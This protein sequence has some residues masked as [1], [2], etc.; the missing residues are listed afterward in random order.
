MHGR[1]KSQ[2]RAVRD[3]RRIS[4]SGWLPPAALV[5]LVLLV[6][7]P[8]LANGFVWDDDSYVTQNDTLRSAHGLWRIWFEPLSIPQYYPL[9]HTTFWLEHH[10]WGDA[11]AGYHAANIAL[12]SASVLLLWI[13][14]ARLRVPGAWLAAALFAVHPVEVETVAWI[15]ERKNLLSLALALGSLQAYFCFASLASTETGT[16]AT[17]AGHQWR[18]YTLSLARLLVALL[19]KTVVATLP[20]VVLVIYWWK[21][22]RITAHDVSPLLPFLALG[23]GLGL[24]TVWIE[25][26][27][28]GA[29]GQEWIFTPV[30]R[31]LIAGR[32]LW[33]YGAKL[34]WPEPLIF[35]Y[36]RWPI[37]PHAGWQYLFP[38][39]ALAAG[40]GLW[41]ARRRVGRGPLAAVLI[42][43][44]VLVP[45]LGFFDVYPF[46]YSF[47]ADHF[48]YHASVALLTLAAAG[49]V[50]LVGRSPRAQW[51]ISL[52]AILPLA[53]VARDRT[54][55][56]A[57][58]VTLHENTLALN[59][60]AWN[61]AVSLGDRLNSEGQYA[62][63]GAQYQRAAKIVQ[64]LLRGQPSA[65]PLTANLAACYVSV[66]LAFYRD[67]KWD[68]AN[69]YFEKAL[70][71]RQELIRDYPDAA[72]YQDALAWSHADIALTNLE[73]GRPAA[74]IEPYRKAIAIR[75]RRA[76]ERVPKNADRHQLAFNY[77]G[78][79]AALRDTGQ[80][81]DGERWLRKATD[82]REQLVSDEP[83]NSNFQEALG[84]CYGELGATE[85]I[86]GELAAAEASLR[87]A[88]RVRR[89]LALERHDHAIYR[90]Q[91][92][93]SYEG[94]GNLS[95]AMHR[96]Q[97]ADEAYAEA[98][99]ID[100]LQPAAH[101]AAPR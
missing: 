69:A 27:H 7:W 60:T 101:P 26:K 85:Q 46:R 92:A 4:W 53:V 49:M 6:Y 62:A 17:P 81:I 38:S 1:K 32:A 96:Q 90:R 37:D 39:G 14:L 22:G 75:E 73:A 80:P 95:R 11:P 43:A 52:G 8:T 44:G 74:A 71:I 40:V 72:E 77:A 65:A 89:Q 30:E 93:A 42:F 76:E 57:D 99:Q 24:A 29:L 87:N 28:V 79:G 98:L 18:W 51:L 100:G 34:A 33:F 91:L 86:N 45:A 84:W 55:A 9:V 66:G 36:R 48:Q 19:S 59:P 21:R 63:A 82:L 54:H 16:A 68:E 41:L 97:D 20:A 13:L 78:L 5:L 94:L 67:R 12:H 70:A 88:I 31:L 50:L 56:F 58:L 15:T 35:F 3:Q 64:T 25:K 2:L 83:A 10:L 61:A 23:V 47:V